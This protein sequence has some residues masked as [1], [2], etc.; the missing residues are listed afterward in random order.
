MNKLPKLVE[1]LLLKLYWAVA[2]DCYYVLSY[3]ILF[4]QMF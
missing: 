2:K 1:A 3:P 4:F